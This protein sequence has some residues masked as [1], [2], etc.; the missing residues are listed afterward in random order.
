MTD[1]FDLSGQTA[2]VTGASGGL[3]RH[4]AMTLARAGAKVALCAR[5]AELLAE[6]AREIQAMDGSAMP[7]VL[8]VTDGQSVRDGVAAAETE[9]GAISIL[10]NNS[11]VADA[12]VGFLEQEEA[13]WDRVMDT[14]LKGAW[15]VAQEVVRHMVRL[16]H[17]GRI[18]NV[19]SILGM[20]AAARVP[21]Y[22]ASKAGL[23]QLTRAMAVELA[24][25]DIRVNALAPG[26]IE[27]D[28]NRGFLHSAA[29]EGLL[30]RIPG[31]RFGQMEDL[32][33]ALLLLASDASSYMTGAVITID[34]GQSAAL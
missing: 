16:G 28:L 17:G 20:R 11:G 24:R 23:I 22:A 14:N 30:K 31:R 10:V 33:G 2:L 15:L 25:H 9:L 29:G 3:G 4:F 8:D 27:T 32:D 5:R 13:D 1:R 34:G 18:V 12:G 6:V 21:A 19:G 7:I 26:Y